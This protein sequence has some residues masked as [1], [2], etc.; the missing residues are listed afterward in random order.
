MRERH[1]PFVLTVVGRARHLEPHAHRREVALAARVHLDHVERIAG[2]RGGEFGGVHGV[3]AELLLRE[4][5]LRVADLPVCH[6]TLRIPLDLHLHIRRRHAQRT[7]ELCGEI[8]RSLLGC[9]DESVA[10]VAVARELFEHVVIQPLP[11]DSEAVERDALLAMRLDLLLQRRGIHVAEIRRAVGEQHD[12]IDAAGLV[13]PQRR[14]VTE[15]QR[16]PEI[17]AALRRDF[18]NSRGQFAGLV[19]RDTVRPQARRAR[20]SD[21]A[22]FILRRELRRERAQPFAHDAHAIRALH[23]A[24]IIE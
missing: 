9:V 5:M 3:V 14:L 6:H 21:D 11:S 18:A 15:I 1:S 17:R 12:V 4:L 8:C 20:E 13:M 23:R 24:G 2:F 10:P 16:S 22:Q 7:G 19:A